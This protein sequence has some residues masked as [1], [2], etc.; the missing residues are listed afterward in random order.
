MTTLINATRTRPNVRLDQL[1]A[2]LNRFEIV[3]GRLASLPPDFDFCLDGP[4]RFGWHNSK[5]GSTVT[6]TIDLADDAKAPELIRE[7]RM[8]GFVAN[9]TGTTPTDPW[10]VR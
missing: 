7:L 8:C 9:V 5:D 3:P 4:S 10:D 2:V 1:A 6:L